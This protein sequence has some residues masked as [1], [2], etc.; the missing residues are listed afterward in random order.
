MTR[1]SQQR[2]AAVVTALLVVA[3]AVTL[4][5]TMFAGQRAAIRT[6]EAQRL[7]TDSVWM[8]RAS[9]EWARLLLREN[10]RTTP[11]DHLGQRWALPVH[12]LPVATVL[13][14]TAVQTFNAVND[15]RVDGTI[16][17]AQARFNLNTLVTAAE[18]GKPPGIRPEGVRV[19]QQLLTRADLDP[20]LAMLTATAILRG[21]DARTS[22]AL[23][24]EQP[25]DL[26]RI[27][28]YSPDGV[29][30][31]AP[32]VV[33]LPEPTSINPNTAAPEVLQAAIQGLS[34][35]QAAALV[36]SRERAWF[37]DAAD[38]TNRL[39]AIAPALP[40]QQDVLLETRSRYFI[41]HSRLRNGRATR[42][43]DALILREGIG[44]R[45]RT[46]VLWVREPAMPGIDG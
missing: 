25:E 46:T 9:V 18:G 24:L 41:A 11:A 35:G 29:R 40:E 3:M 43:L 28:G 32:Y 36:S 27:P 45:Y 12:D 19:Y 30:K 21:L 5:A 34:P 17:D 8:Q 1:A 26:L 44:E 20:S 22:S 10:A 37:R 23:P 13:G 4:V 15:M 7:R 39:K 16:E 14:K 2:G 31:L 33:V 42:L 38:L 6:V